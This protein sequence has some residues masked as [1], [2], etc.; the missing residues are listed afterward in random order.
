[1]L[2]PAVGVKLGN[3]DCVVAYVSQTSFNDLGETILTRLDFQRNLRL[4]GMDVGDATE[5][6]FEHWYQLMGIHCLHRS[7]LSGILLPLRPNIVETTTVNGRPLFLINHINEEWRFTFE[8]LLAMELTKLQ[9][10][11]FRIM[12]NTLSKVT[13]SVPCYFTDTERR[14]VLNS[15][16]ISGLKCTQLVD[17]ITAIAT[18][19]AYKTRTVLSTDS[20]PKIVAFVDVGYIG[21]QVAV[22]QFQKTQSN[23]IAFDYD[24]RIGGRDFDRIIFQHVIDSYPYETSRKFTVPSKEGKRILQKC[25]VAKH[26]RGKMRVDCR[27]QGGKVLNFVIEKDK[28][29][30]YCQDLLKR[31]RSLLESCLTQLDPEVKVDHVELTSSL[32][33]HP[34]LK[35]IVDDVFKR[36]SGT[37]M[38]DKCVSRGCALQASLQSSTESAFTFHTQAIYPHPIRIC[39][40][41]NKHIILTTKWHKIPSVNVIQVTYRGNVAMKL[42]HTLPHNGSDS[43]DLWLGTITLPQLENNEFHTVQL[44][45]AL[46][47]HG[48][49]EINC[50]R[51][52]ECKTELSS[53][54]TSPES[55]TG[56][57][58]SVSLM[59]PRTTSSNEYDKGCLTISSVFNE[60]TPNEVERF[61]EVEQRQLRTHDEYE[62]RRRELFNELGSLTLLYAKTNRLSSNLV[63]LNEWSNTK[64]ENAAATDIQQIIDQL[65]IVLDKDSTVEDENKL[66]SLLSMDDGKP[67]EE[68]DIYLI[69]PN[70]SEPTK[71]TISDTNDDR[72]NA[73]ISEKVDVDSLQKDSC[74]SVKNTTPDKQSELDDVEFTGE[75][76]GNFTK[77]LNQSSEPA[78]Y[79]DCDRRNKENEVE[80]TERRTSWREKIQSGWFFKNSEPEN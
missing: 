7:D 70:D 24:R 15:T 69:E 51:G 22:C 67:L 28:F 32:C 17:E 74:E 75:A 44:I 12:K 58:R 3:I 4:V 66:L 35:A 53:T 45:I 54:T 30:A 39:W 42:Q 34:M 79:S 57:I 26:Q 48:C 73:E 10:V 27:V 11:W 6:S 38:V 55:T 31:F 18:Y 19:Y 65:K 37:G 68:K 49:I 40:P 29:E 46:N 47:V 59:E 78:K 76:G 43:E 77:S 60:L 14:V 50:T 62:R 36:N 1:M 9:E 5:T 25:E 64:G 16:R 61:R 23:V 20:V 41:E 52:V 56:E 72:E 21:T 2:D 63:K 8:Q 13:L 71:C 33:R 80:F